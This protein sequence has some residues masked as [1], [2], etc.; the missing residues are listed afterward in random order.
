MIFASTAKIDD[1]VIC[2]NAAF[3]VNAASEG[4]K[5]SVYFLEMQ[6]KLNDKK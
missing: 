3:C 2:I 6:S 4:V 5:M 1:D